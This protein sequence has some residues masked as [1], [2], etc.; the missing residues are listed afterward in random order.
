MF[1]NQEMG[2]TASSGPAATAILLFSSSALPS[3]LNGF[4]IDSFL[5]LHVRFDTG[6]GIEGE[7]CN[8]YS[9]HVCV[10]VI[11][12]VVVRVVDIDIDIIS[13]TRLSRHRICRHF[14]C[15]VVDFLL[16]RPKIRIIRLM[17][18]EARRLVKTLVDNHPGRPLQHQWDCW[19]VPNLPRCGWVSRRGSGVEQIQSI[20]MLIPP[21]QPR[22]LSDV[23]LGK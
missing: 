7:E 21:E 14:G 13:A 18:W 12:V 11:T 1:Q 10:A 5:I 3:A 4:T 8:R 6:T 19:S 15:V 20:Y 16:G 23:I 22:I 17:G 2:F 9:L